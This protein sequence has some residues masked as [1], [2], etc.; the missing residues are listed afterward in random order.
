MK[1]L[2]K[3]IRQTLKVTKGNIRFT[4]TLPLFG[5]VMG[6]LAGIAVV[7]MDGIENGY[8]YVGTIMALICMGVTIFAAGIV[9]MPSEFN[10]AL[11]MG[12]VR[13]HLVVAQYVAWI[14]NTLIALVICLVGS[15]I[16]ECLYR[17]I[18]PGAVCE[19][20]LRVFFCNPV[21]FLTILLCVPALAL[22][23]NA[24]AMKFGQISIFIVYFVPTIVVALSGRAMRSPDS[25]LGR[26]TTEL[27]EV[28]L[29]LCKAPLTYIVLGI[30]CV[31]FANLILRKQRV[32][33]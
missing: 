29:K 1:E 15:V 22:F 13:K 9:Q 7:Y 4:I 23:E 20:N 3:T 31:L 25:F 19:V 26:M 33:Y 14:R 2:T 28:L 24:I 12:K 10:M 30:I 8:S 5:Y 6:L 16:E 21:Y 17:S 18:Y 27:L 11:S 32:T